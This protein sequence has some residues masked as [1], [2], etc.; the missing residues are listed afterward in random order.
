MHAS[1]PVLCEA[2][3]GTCH[4]AVPIEGKS[5][6]QQVRADDPEIG[7]A[8]LAD[9]TEILDLLHAL[10]YLWEAA[11][12]FHAKD[13]DFARAFVKAQARRILHGEVAG[14]DIGV[15]I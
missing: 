11:H 12:L 10:G 13:S 2:E 8:P 4:V 9:V 14:Q 3:S 15:T 1:L 6:Y 7:I 5:R